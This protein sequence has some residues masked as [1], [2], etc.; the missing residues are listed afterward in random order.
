MVFRSR[1]TVWLILL[2]NAFFVPKIYFEFHML[3]WMN[4]LFFVGLELMLIISI[5]GIRYRIE[6]TTLYVGWH[7]FRGTAYDLTKLNK[8]TASRTWIS[9]PAASLRRIKLDF[10]CGKPLIISP[11]NQNLF[12]EEILRIN[13]NVKVD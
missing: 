13:P 12:I 1:I 4:I 5:S 7:F 6:D 9:A 11:A 10:G 3:T 8:I 2:L